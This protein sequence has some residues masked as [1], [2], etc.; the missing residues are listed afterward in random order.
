MFRNLTFFSK[1]IL[2][3]V[4]SI[5][6]VGITLI[7]ISYFI[8]GEL[9]QKQ[10]HDQTQQISA[11]W[12]KQINS[13]EVL[14]LIEDHDVKSEVHQKYTDL[15]NKMSQYN[16]IVSQGYIFG[17]ELTG[18]R[19]NETS[20]IS[21]NSDIWNMLLEEKMK[22]GAMY[23][24]PD[25]VVDAL[26]LLKET[27]EPQ[28]TRTY[29]DDF[30]TWVTF[31]YPIV[32][33]NEQLI[34]YYAI[35]VDASSIGAGQQGLLKWSA[36]ILII[37]LLIVS[38]LQYFVVKAQLKPLLYLLEG[39]NEASKGNLALELPEGK[40]EL[41]VVNKSFNEMTKALKKMVEQVTHSAVD[42]KQGAHQLEQT[43]TETYASSKNI[44]NSVQQIQQT[45]QQQQHAIEESATTVEHM[46]TQVHQIAGETSTMYEQAKEVTTFSE[47]GKLLTKSVVERMEVIVEDV[48]VSNNH[49]EGLVKL[50]EEIG[51][52]L[53]IINDVSSST[54]LLAL[55]ASI[56]AARAGEHGKGFA[57]VAEEV[58]KL[59]EQS[60]QS[61]EVIRGLVN[62]V[63]TAVEQTA[64]AM[65]NIKIGVTDGQQVTQQTN[66]MFEQ[67]YMF[68]KE[69]TNKMQAISAAT[70][71]LS[72]GAQQSTAMT[73]TISTNS[74]DIVNSY[75]EMTR[76]VEHQ[77]LT[78]EQLNMMSKQLNETSE[79][80]Q[81]VVRKF[82]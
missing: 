8:Q 71:Q 55:N 10:L 49:I 73:F 78:I 30:G 26:K 5:L 65:N 54:S 74:N 58:K 80:L 68:N 22:P 33:D 9:L 15:F 37:L 51:A 16:P 18:E 64:N 72:A 14:T 50:S 46:S 53:S 6:F 70:E 63:R 32:D 82:E 21:F 62:R 28:F 40:D 34:A 69:M 67:I 81:Q 77:R 27:K 2:V 1:N 29:S 47:E 7:S 42:V 12:Y 25:V 4:S 24:Q 79:Q 19:Q 57:V 45:L 20:L 75:E 3:L 60:A 17:V 48:Q 43:F 39:I 61:T 56:E 13:D 52:M 41:G 59:S 11:S 38:A 31:M 23:E 44:T 76:N 35:D 66:E 36:F